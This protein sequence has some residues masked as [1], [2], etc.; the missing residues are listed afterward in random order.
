MANRIEWNRRAIN[1]LHAIIGYFLKQ[2]AR[3][4]AA[5]FNQLVKDKIIKLDQN[6]TVG[7]KAPKAKTIYFV[8]LG[9][10]H[11]MYYRKKGSTLRIV[12][13]FDTR[14]DTSKRPY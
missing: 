11:R 12:C 3:Q 6:K 5:N 4:A 13:F 8:L 10:H 2:E 14:Q 1:D 9:K 7:R